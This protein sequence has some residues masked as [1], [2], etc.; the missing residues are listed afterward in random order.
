MTTLQGSVLQAGAGLLGFDADSK[1]SADSAIEFYN[2]GYRFCLRYLSLQTA[3]QQSD[4]TNEEAAGILQG[5]LA[6]MAVQ[7]VLDSG[8][9]PTTSLGKSHGQNA[10]Q[11]AQSIDL[12]TGI[13]IWCDL[14]GVESKTQPASVID[15]CNAWF[16]AV[17]QADYIP[18]LY[19]GANNGLTD[20]ELNHTLRF[21]H[22]WKS[23]SNVPNITNRGYQLIQSASGPVNGVSIDADNTQADNEG[24]LPYWLINA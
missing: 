19:V 7:H 20:I 18:G 13:N 22:Y 14:E 8:W 1:I 3:E 17:N 5:G 10:A 4:L 11:N 21:K 2:S 23:M 12:P 15:Y 6:L 24:G 9:S 16:D